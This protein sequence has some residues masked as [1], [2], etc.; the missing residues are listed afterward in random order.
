MP[1]S[2]ATHP[3]VALSAGASGERLV[4]GQGVDEGKSEEAESRSGE[5]QQLDAC[6]A[7]RAVHHPDR[8]GGLARFGGREATATRTGKTAAAAPTA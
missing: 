6:R 1:R 8:C 3:S 2:P 5:Q 7:R 4:E